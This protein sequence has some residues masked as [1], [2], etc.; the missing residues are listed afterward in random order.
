MRKY[1]LFS[2][3]VI[4]TIAAFGSL[5]FSEI[6]QT[7]PCILSWF[8][9]ICLYPLVII[10]GQAAWYGDYRI[11]LYL[12]PQTAIGLIIALYHL[13]LQETHWFPYLPSC[14]V[15]TDVGLGFVS[16]PL[17]S[18]FAFILINGLLIWIWRI[19]KKGLHEVL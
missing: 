6:L 13:L 17:L 15:K 18:L 2:V 1:G 5:Y 16:V 4:A 8:Q 14:A 3:W 7:T 19:S 10:A 12:L 9:R 11:A